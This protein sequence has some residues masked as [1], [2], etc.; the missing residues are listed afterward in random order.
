VLKIRSSIPKEIQKKKSRAI[1][2]SI[3]RHPYFQETDVLFCY[4]DFHDEVQTGMLIHEAMRL[5]KKVAVPKVDKEDMNF[6]FVTGHED[7]TP[8]Y[9]GIPEPDPERCKLADEMQ[10]ALMIVPGTAFDAACNRMGYG[11][12]FYDRYLA[13]HPQLHTIGIAYEEQIVTGLPTEETDWK[14]DFVITEKHSYKK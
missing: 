14:L 11:K 5:G 7:L 6:Y 1:C 4:M 12:G 8:G 9:F 10:N 13:G 2:E 3:M